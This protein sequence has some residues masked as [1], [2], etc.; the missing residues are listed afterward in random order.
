MINQFS[1]S[2]GANIYIFTYKELW[3]I[4]LFLN[5][6]KHSSSDVPKVKQAMSESANPIS[7]VLDRITSSSHPPSFYIRYDRTDASSN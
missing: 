4:Q 6:T 7:I 5:D 3:Y 1:P 2:L